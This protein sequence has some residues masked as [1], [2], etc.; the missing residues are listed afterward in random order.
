MSLSKE[1]KKFFCCLA[2]WMSGDEPA[3][4]IDDSA[5]RLYEC[6][7]GDDA[8]DYQRKSLSEVPKETSPDLGLFNHDKDADVYLKTDAVGDALT[9]DAIQHALRLLGS[10]PKRPLSAMTAKVDSLAY[11]YV[12]SRNLTSPEEARAAYLA[13]YSAAIDTLGAYKSIGASDE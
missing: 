3:H 7:C 4:K 6:L 8:A 13:G 9:T 2:V 11:A 12:D 1:D 10:P 5:Q